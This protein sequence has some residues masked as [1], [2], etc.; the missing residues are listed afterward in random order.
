MFHYKITCYSIAGVESHGQETK[1]I[2]N[3]DTAVEAKEDDSNKVLFD[4][5]PQYLLLVHF[6]RSLRC[7][8]F[9]GEDT[10]C[11]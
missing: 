9:F 3:S 7:C 4:I 5:L 1:S 10:N 11:I 8:K 6:C 2:E